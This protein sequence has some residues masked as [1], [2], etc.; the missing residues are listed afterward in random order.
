MENVF[1]L[2]RLA[3]YIIIFFAAITLLYAMFSR[4]DS[5]IDKSIDHVA[6]DTVMYEAYITEK[7]HYSARAELITLLLD[8]LEYDLEIVDESGSYAIIADGYSPDDIGLYV[9]TSENY[10][11]SYIYN[12]N[13]TIFKIAFHYVTE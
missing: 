1:K 10:K 8:K 4:T 12:L 5:L 11:K 9:L 3:F 13:G 6:E 7:N 2:L